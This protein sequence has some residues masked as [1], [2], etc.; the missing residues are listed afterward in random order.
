LEGDDAKRSQTAHH[1]RFFAAKPFFSA[2]NAA[3]T[4]GSWVRLG[5]FPIWALAE[6]ILAYHSEKPRINARFFRILLLK[7]KG[8]LVLERAKMRGSCRQ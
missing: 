6:A 7:G 4:S 3:H 2:K 1:E 5:I 8:L